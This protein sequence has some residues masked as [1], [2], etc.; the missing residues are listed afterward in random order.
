MPRPRHFTGSIKY[1]NMR[2]SALKKSGSFFLEHR[3]CVRGLKRSNLRA[4]PGREPSWVHFG[5][6]KVKMRR[7]AAL[8]PYAWVWFTDALFT[9]TLR[10]VLAPP[11]QKN[12]KP[13][14]KQKR[15]KKLSR[16]QELYTEIKLLFENTSVIVTLRRRI[17]SRCLYSGRVVG[18]VNCPPQRKKLVCVEDRRK[19]VVLTRVWAHITDFIMD[20]VSTPKLS[21][22]CL[23]CLNT[24]MVT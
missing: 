5:A 3:A 10:L 14:K 9:R 6:W 15:K 17:G 23:R 24:E 12:K 18:H 19:G 1:S 21:F 2:A 16:V 11:R 7:E 4:D 13:K 22:V 8:P 20:D